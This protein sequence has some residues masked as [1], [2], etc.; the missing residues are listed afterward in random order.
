[1]SCLSES[2]VTDRAHVQIPTSLV[3][4]PSKGLR[5]IGINSFG[6]GGSNGH[7][8]MDDAY[9]VLESLGQKA[10]HHTIVDVPSPATN[11][12]GHVNGDEPA[13]E[14]V[15][16]GNGHEAT[17][18][19]AEATETATNGNGHEA[20]NGHAEVAETATNGNGHEA[21]NGHAATAA[22]DIQPSD[23]KLLVWSAKDEAALKRVLQQ[24]SKHYEVAGLDQ[25]LETLAYTL[26]QRRSIMSWKSFTVTNS[27][28]GPAAISKS[29]SSS[30]RSSRQST[31]AF[32]FTGQGA[33]YAKM[34]LE[35]IQYPIFKSTLEQI[36]G[37]FTQLG[38]EWSLFGEY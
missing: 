11:G 16:N 38:A 2:I 25:D 29:V 36:G 17:N 21:V 35:L 33:Q 3:P 22:P 30:T 26:S 7:V 19:H 27:K 4:W 8:I 20:V 32:V 14:A 10:N 6:F 34:G 37:I 31:L 23:L 9:H 1:M 24:Y 28:A 18:G 15:T 5:R 13:A 12:N